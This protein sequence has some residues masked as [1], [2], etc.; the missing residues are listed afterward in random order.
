MTKEVV[1]LLKRTIDYT[2]CCG[3]AQAM[4]KAIEE[5]E[6]LRPAAESWESYVAAQER[7]GA[8]AEPGSGSCYCRTGTGL[9]DMA[10][11]RENRVCG[12]Q[13]R[14]QRSGSILPPSR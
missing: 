13:E 11:R 9:P 12:M 4:Q 10:R 5:I 14:L 3:S 8:S 2:E 1:E 6:R 7:K